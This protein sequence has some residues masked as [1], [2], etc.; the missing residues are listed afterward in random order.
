MSPIVCLHKAAVFLV[1][2][3]AAEAL[4][5]ELVEVGEGGRGPPFVV[6]MI[7]PCY[8]LRFEDPRDSQRYFNLR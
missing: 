7:W 5:C 8:V 6:A 1:C 4:S 3:V 2:I